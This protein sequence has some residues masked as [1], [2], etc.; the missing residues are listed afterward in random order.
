MI[1]NVVDIPVTWA[2]RFKLIKQIDLNRMMIHT[3]YVR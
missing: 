3:V 2:Y 1:Y